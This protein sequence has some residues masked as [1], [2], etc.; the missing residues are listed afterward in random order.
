M[1]ENHISKNC[2]HI[3]II[4]LWIS[5]FVLIQLS[6]PGVMLTQE[7][8]RRRFTECSR[9]SKLLNKT[10]K[11]MFSSEWQPKQPKK[12]KFLSNEK[13]HILH[14][15]I[16][17]YDHIMYR[18]WDMLRDRQTNGQKKWHIE[19]SVSPKKLGN[20]I[21]LII[22]PYSNMSCISSAARIQG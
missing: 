6:V 15:C 3:T 5:A 16:K 12:S 13:K 10:T 22:Y 21:V 17:N 9:N 7:V 20:S 19:A 11:S 8:W 2:T 4:L 1:V 14:K 18:S